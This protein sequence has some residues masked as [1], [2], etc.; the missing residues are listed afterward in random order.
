MLADSG[1]IYLNLLKLHTNKLPSPLG[2]SVLQKL[3]CLEVGSSCKIPQLL[4]CLGGD[5]ASLIRKSL[6]YCFSPSALGLVIL[7][8]T[9]C[10]ESKPFDLPKY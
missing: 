2:H 3:P 4:I 7:D 10:S 1:T 8:F 9:S 5:F 6:S